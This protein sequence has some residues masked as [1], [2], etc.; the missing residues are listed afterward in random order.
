MSAAV[1]GLCE[2]LSAAF[3]RFFGGFRFATGGRYVELARHCR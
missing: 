1:V 3:D 2:R